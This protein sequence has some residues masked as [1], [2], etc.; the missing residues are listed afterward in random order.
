MRVEFTY[1]QKDLIDVNMRILRRSKTVLRGRRQAAIFLIIFFWLAIYV[2]FISWLGNP[3][4]AVMMLVVSTLT[5]IALH[6]ISHKHAL[7]KRLRSLCKESYGDRDSFQ[8]EVELTPVEVRIRDENTQTVYE[9]KSIE[10]VV[11]TEDSV[12]LFTRAGGG[13]VVRNRAFE[14]PA[15]RADFIA[16]A[17]QYLAARHGDTDQK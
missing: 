12:D 1:N 7:E 15:K 5:V 8:C 3:Y 13:V 6:P 10:E 17:Q 2:V 4:L 16:L 14:S 9:W 11:L